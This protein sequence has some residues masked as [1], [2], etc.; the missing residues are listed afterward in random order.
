[1]VIT[2]NSIPVIV[3]EKLRIAQLDSK[4]KKERLG[5]TE[6]RTARETSNTNSQILV[7]FLAFRSY[8]NA[9]LRGSLTQH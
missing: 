6:A 5:E 7:S 2:V 9:L 8:K 3:I 1:M 4:N